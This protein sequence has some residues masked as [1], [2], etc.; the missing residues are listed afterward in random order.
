M[1]KERN[2]FDR[3][4]PTL[5]TIKPRNINCV[6]NTP[7]INGNT[8]SLQ[9]TSASPTNSNKIEPTPSSAWKISQSKS[10][11][12]TVPNSPPNGTSTS[13][14]IRDGVESEMQ[15]ASLIVPNVQ[16]PK[17]L[18]KNRI[19]LLTKKG[20]NKKKFE[21]LRK[22]TS[23]P[24]LPIPPAYQENYAKL[25]AAA[26]KGAPDPKYVAPKPLEKKNWNCCT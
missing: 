26:R 9:S 7:T 25:M 13:P 6:G 24:N 2:S 22:A 15:L 21:S 10:N 20:P 16:P 3:N 17:V 12:L 1:I 23:E 18:T 19:E 4:F 14:N 8:S 5:N 11:P